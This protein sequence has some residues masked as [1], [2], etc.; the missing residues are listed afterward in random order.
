MS[1]DSK[2]QKKVLFVCLG[3][4]CRSTMAEIVFR[5]L[6]HS[7]GILDGFQ[8]D[9]AGTS[10]YHIGDTPD[11]RTVQACNQNMGKAISE[12]SLKHFKSIPLH[13]ARQFTDEDFSK[14]DYIFAMDESNLSNIKKVL[15]HSTTKDNHIASVKRLGEY[16]T[17]KKINVEDPYYG[18]MSNF[19]IC[20]NHVHD[21]LVNFLKELESLN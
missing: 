1:V 6:V 13:R 10:S 20:F 11:P 15:K 7:R 2:S 8:I 12:E 4:I 3:N 21:C 17:H 14:F 9:S 19:N 5:G 16:H 18:D